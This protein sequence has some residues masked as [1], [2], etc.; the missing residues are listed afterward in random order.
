MHLIL[1]QLLLVATPFLAAATKGKRKSAV[2]PVKRQVSKSRASLARKKPAL[3]HKKS[4]QPRKK[5]AQANKKP[6]QAKKRSALGQNKLARSKKTRRQAKGASARQLETHGKKNLSHG[7][8]LPAGKPALPIAPK[9][10]ESEP[11]PKP[12]APTGRAILLSPENEKYADSEHPT[13]RWLSVGG[14]TRYEIAWSDDMAMNASH[15]IF[16]IATEATIPVEKPL[17]AGA[18]YH[19]RVRGGNESGWGPWSAV[20]SF[21]VL[22]E[23][24]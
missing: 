4:A 22:E 7:R 15:S 2:K 3:A 13:F 23:P 8:T 10:D 21:R 24:T 9:P 6:M 14:A 18:A 5:T 17:H 12:V 1:E 20:S 16:S 11:L 19:W